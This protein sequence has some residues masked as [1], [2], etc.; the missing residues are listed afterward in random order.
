MPLNNLQYDEIIREYQAKQIQNQHIVDAR[1]KEVYSKDSRLKGI[2]DA[3]SSCSVAQAR[4]MLDGDSLALADLHQ[5]LAEYKKQRLAI[6]QELGY[7]E[8]YFEPSYA[9]PDC[10]D[11][12]YIGNDRCHCF[13]QRAID[14]VYTQSNIRGIL[15]EENFDTFSYNYYSTLEINPSTGL[16]SLETMQNAVKTCHKFIHEFDTDFSNLF[17]YGDTG[18]GKTFLSNCIAKELLDTG[19]SVIYFTAFQ[20]FDIFEKNTFHKDTPEDMLVAHQNIFDCDLLIIDDLG[21]EMPNSFTISHLFL[22]LNERILRRK[23]TII[24]TNL[25]LQQM[26]DIY[27]ERTFSRISSNYVMLKLFGDDIRIQKKLR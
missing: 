23:S 16:T 3:I 25:S 1:I 9:C 18:V 26:A 7:S 19:H 17:I 24:S 22:C 10:K 21:T 6:L 11:T 8:Q 14:L 12:G 4:K 20:L 13:K 27:S 5:Q 15:K 2:D